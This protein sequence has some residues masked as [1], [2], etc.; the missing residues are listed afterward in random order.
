MGWGIREARPGGRGLGVNS[1]LWQE[2]EFTPDPSSEETRSFC[3]QHQGNSQEMRM[4][5]VAS[6]SSTS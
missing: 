6:N 2:T 5:S 4:L 3:G 1:G